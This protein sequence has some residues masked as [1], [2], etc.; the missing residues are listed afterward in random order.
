MKSID[1]LR[2]D[3]PGAAKVLHFNNCGS[4]L[5]PAAVVNA[6]IEHLLLE[7][8]VGGY[9]AAASNERN[10]T[11]YP[12]AARL[13]GCRA[14]EIAFSNSASCAWNG[15]IDS[16]ALRRN[17]EILTSRIECGT[18]LS[19][20]RHLAMRTGAV[21]KILASRPDGT[22]DLNDLARRL[23]RRTKLVAGSPPPPPSRAGEPSRE[24]VKHRVAPPPH[25]PLPPPPPLRLHTL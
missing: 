24:R 1:D 14:E 5:P 8:D 18:N 21:P 22:V 2:N 6:Q 9:E 19:A 15:F 3:T 20:L 17:D 25:L 23:C 16:L 10:R 11:V 4:A 13:L 7:R 12:A